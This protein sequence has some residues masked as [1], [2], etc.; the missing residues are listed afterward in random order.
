M[1]A[2]GH[3]SG[4]LDTTEIFNFGDWSWREGPRLPHA[5]SMA[6]AVQVTNQVAYSTGVQ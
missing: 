1:V 2:G 4:Y 6:E 3:Y 5:I